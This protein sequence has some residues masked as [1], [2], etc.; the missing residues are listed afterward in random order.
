M[1]GHPGGEEHSRYL[2]ELSFVEPPA[3][4]LDMGAG[5]GD[6]VIAVMALALAGGLNPE[7]GAYLANTAASVVVGKLGTYAVSR[8][9]LSQAVDEA[10]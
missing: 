9:E 5:A 3:R 7:D 4:W 8:Q 2:I 6:T 10:E 1:Q